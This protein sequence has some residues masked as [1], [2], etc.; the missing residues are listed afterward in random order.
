MSWLDEIEPKITE[1]EALNKGLEIVDVDGIEYAVE[2]AHRYQL[3][4]ES[5][6]FN[7]Q[8][9]VYRVVKEEE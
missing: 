8:G 6:K 3:A 4:I 1:K 2:D 9:T 5:K 7:Y